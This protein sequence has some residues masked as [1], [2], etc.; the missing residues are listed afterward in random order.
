MAQFTVLGGS[1]FIGSHLISHLREC[2]HPVFVPGRGEGRIYREPLGHVIYAIGVTA[3]FRT[4]PYAT[5]DAHVAV[6][7]EILRRARFESF[8]YLSSTRLYAGAGTTA[9]DS[10]FRV[11]PA[12]ASDLYNLSKLAGE[13]L[14]LAHRQPSVRVARLS[15]V[16]GDGMG[17]E[18]F[19]AVILREA[20][21]DARIV[22]RTGPD[23][24]KD[25]VAVDDVARALRLIAL[26]GTHRIY[27]IGAGGNVS[28]AA[29]TAA[30]ARLTGSAIE[31]QPGAPVTSFPTIDT[32]RL[33]S[34][35]AGLG[36][37]WAPADL[38]DRLPALVAG[39]AREPAA[40]AGGNA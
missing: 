10:A 16:Y 6:L 38:L 22:L 31:V 30:L 36:A 3:D 5:M 12:D 11:D 20:V 2:G 19:L 1:G 4:R 15:N 29:L 9:E 17:Y 26:G 28:H 7:G 40:A 14:C 33:A 8:T 39:T 23:S 25:Y 27:N 37:K 34:L 21:Y 32:A 35:F 24:A 13:A 18:N